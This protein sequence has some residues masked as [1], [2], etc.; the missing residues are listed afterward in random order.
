M[1][2]NNLKNNM[3]IKML[4]ETYIQVM[5]MY[6]MGHALANDDPFLSNPTCLFI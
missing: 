4:P 6:E 5:L 3:L 2:N 1:Q